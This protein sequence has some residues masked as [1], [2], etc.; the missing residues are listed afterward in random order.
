MMTRRVLSIQT[1]PARPL[2]VEGRE[3][4]TAHRKRPVEGP[5]AVGPLGLAGDGRGDAGTHG[6]I[7]RAIYAYPHEHYAVWQTLRAQAGL[8]PWGAPAEPGLLGENLTLTGLLESQAWVGD[9]LRF[10]GCALAIS[11]PRLPCGRL[12]AAMGFR[13]AARMMTQ[14]GYCGFFLA[15][16]EPGV[17]RAG[18]AFEVVPG[19]REVSI[20]ELF[21][22]RVAIEKKDGKD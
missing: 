20:A 15:V 16:R 22:A 6:G 11:E 9:L 21:R 13:H 19:P 18:D 14:S 10:P 17:I 4:L 2:F 1:G 5:V 8:A 12:D 3:V 7:A